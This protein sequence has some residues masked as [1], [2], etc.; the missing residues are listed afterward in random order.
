[1]QRYGKEKKKGE[2]ERRREKKRE[3][4]RKRGKRK[5][6]RG[7]ELWPLVNSTSL[8]AMADCLGCNGM[9]K[10]RGDKKREKER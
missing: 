3:E 7:E 2:S 9:G 4:K 1:M 5:E 6:K 8:N 10:R